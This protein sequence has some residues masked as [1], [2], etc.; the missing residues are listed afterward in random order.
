M[1]YQCHC[2]TEVAYVEGA[3]D[4]TCRACAARFPIVPPGSTEPGPFFIV[5]HP[6]PRPGPA[7]RQL[8]ATPSPEDSEDEHPPKTHDPRRSPMST[9]SS[10][11]HGFRGFRPLNASPSDDPD[12]SHDPKLDGGTQEMVALPAETVPIVPTGN[13]S[14]LL[15]PQSEMTVTPAVQRFSNEVEKNR[16]KIERSFKATAKKVYAL[17]AQVLNAAAAEK[18]RREDLRDAKH[19]RDEAEKKAKE[20][21]WGEGGRERTVLTWMLLTAMIVVSILDWFLDQG[22]LEVLYLSQ[23]Q[24]RML[25]LVPTA[26]AL[27]TAHAGGAYLKR[28]H[29]AETSYAI[30]TSER[31]IGRGAIALGIINALVIGG[32]R[33][34]LSGPI[35]GML[36]L[37]AALGLWV[38]LLGFVYGWEAPAWQAFQQA[39]RKVR[40]RAR[41]LATASSRKTKRVQRFNMVQRNLPADAAVA[42]EKVRGIAYGVYNHHQEPVPVNL[43][44]PEWM[45]PMFTVVEGEFPPELSLTAE[46]ITP[47]LDGDNGP[48]SNTPPPAGELGQAAA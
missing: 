32:L 33:W 36:F 13:D 42:I 15:M 44:R 24:T 46:E 11:P 43:P 9:D 30:G 34:W 41:R 21:K 3:E 40:R 45:R 47:P 37:V 16:P 2:G 10:Y 19:D 29:L 14:S 4:L 1:H 25:A 23:F 7:P 17:K 22:A 38:V 18:R 31:W 35:G 12:D 48:P 39:I 28:K 27:L 26:V 5:D 8:P 20:P 6:K